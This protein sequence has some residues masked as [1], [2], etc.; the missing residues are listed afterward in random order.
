MLTLAA[1]LV[2]IIVKPRDRGQ[3]ETEFAS[4]ELSVDADDVP[5]LEFRCLDNGDVELTRCGLA[6]LDSGCSVALAITRIGFD[7]SIEERVT[8]GVDGGAPVNR[9]TF[10]LEGLAQE[11]YHVTYNSSAYSRFLSTSLPN[12]PGIEFRREFRM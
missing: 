11:R 6:G 12:R 7:I 5:R 9:A 1:L 4:G 10:V 8:R 3:A 2:G